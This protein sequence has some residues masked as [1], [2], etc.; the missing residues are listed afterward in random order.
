MTVET[1][2]YTEELLE[3]C[4]LDSA[5]SPLKN[6]FEEFLEGSIRF[7]ED[8]RILQY[9]LTQHLGHVFWRFCQFQHVLDK[10]LGGF[11]IVSIDERLGIKLFCYARVAPVSPVL[12]INE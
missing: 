1:G 4:A 2:G 9:R 7:F 3:R 5:R 6:A 12:F 10:S 8:I 11:E